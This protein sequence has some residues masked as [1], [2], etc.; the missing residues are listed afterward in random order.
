MEHQEDKVDRHKEDVVVLFLRAALLISLPLN[1]QEIIHAESLFAISN[2]CSNNMNTNDGA[3]PDVKGLQEIDHDTEA[4]KVVSNPP[5][6]LEVALRNYVPGTLEEKH[7]VRKVDLWM[8]PMLWWMCVLCYIDRNN[9]VS[10]PR[11]FNW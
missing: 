4:C 8:I 6:A 1:C 2:T 5:T 10:I 7:L 9:I 11:S 3:A